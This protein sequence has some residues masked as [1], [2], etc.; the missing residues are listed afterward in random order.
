[1]GVDVGEGAQRRVGEQESEQE[2]EG[3]CGEG[4]MDART[5]PSDS[6]WHQTGISPIPTD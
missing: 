1:M 6:G 5:Q 4:S 3:H 2:S